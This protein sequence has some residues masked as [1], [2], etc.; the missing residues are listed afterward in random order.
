MGVCI[1][2]AERTALTATGSVTP[3]MGVCIETLLRCGWLLPTC[4][5]TLY[6]CVY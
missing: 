1:E 5:H 4:G 2:T 6:G 3:Y